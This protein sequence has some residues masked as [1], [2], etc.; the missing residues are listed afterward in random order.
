MNPA[1]SH[2][3]PMINYYI[4]LLE[5][6]DTPAFIKRLRTRKDDRFRSSLLATVDTATRRQVE[7]NKFPGRVRIA[8]R[9]RRRLQVFSKQGSLNITGPSSL[10]LLLSYFSLSR[11]SLT[12][13][14]DDQLDYS[15]IIRLQG[16]CPFAIT[17][18]ES[19]CSK[20]SF[21]CKA[22]QSTWKPGQ[23][24]CHRSCRPT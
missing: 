1:A 21:D 10:S 7:A 24:A 6:R 8:D 20:T 12:D 19:S 23:R 9:D 15:L 13:C 17:A 11:D 3:S 18:A 4:L 5:M 16:S 22:S 14:L 2:V